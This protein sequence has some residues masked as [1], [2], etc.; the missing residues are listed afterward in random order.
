MVYV[1]SPGTRKYLSG[2]KVDTE[3][4]IVANGADG[5]FAYS[6][7]Q[8]LLDQRPDVARERTLDQLAGNIVNAGLTLFCLLL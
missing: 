6:R 1:Y 8:T 7:R 2:L 4:K 3:G 5:H